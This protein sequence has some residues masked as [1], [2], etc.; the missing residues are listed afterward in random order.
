MSDPEIT[1]TFSKKVIVHSWVKAGFLLLVGFSSDLSPS[2]T[3]Q[4]FGYSL[5]SFKENSDKNLP[6]FGPRWRDNS[7][8]IPTFKN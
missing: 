1:D 4:K 3:V 5:N 6:F 2:M 8:A 7:L